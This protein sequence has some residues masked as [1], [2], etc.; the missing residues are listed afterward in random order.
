MAESE[1]AVSRGA[2]RQIAFY[3]LVVMLFYT[4]GTPGSNGLANIPIQYY[5]KDRLHFDAVQTASFNFVAGLPLYFGFLLGYLRDRWRPL[6]RGDLGYIVVAPPLIAAGYLWLAVSPL[7]YPGLVIA[8]LLS[9]TF[10]VLLGASIQGLMTQIAQ[11]HAMAGR[12]SVVVMLTTNVPSI[13]SPWAGGWLTAHRPPQFTFFV[14]ALMALAVSAAA[15]W[16]PRA[17]FANGGVAPT[18]SDLSP[19]GAGLPA[20]GA[21]AQPAYD[22]AVQAPAAGDAGPAQRA[23]SAGA[24]QPASRALPLDGSE[25]ERR[26]AA[27]GHADPVSRAV[28]PDQA[29]PASR[30]LS[31]GALGALLRHPALIFPVAIMFFWNFS[32]GW[33]TPLFYYLTNSVGFSPEQYGSFGSIQN[34][35]MVVFTLVYLLLCRRL[36][37]IRLLWLG[38]VLGVIGA[39][40]LLI[41]HGWPAAVFVAVFTG[42][43][44][45]IAVSAYTDLLM[46]ACPRTLEGTVFMLGS[47]MFALAGACSDV[48]GSWLFK[49]GGFGLA[50]LVTAI[51]TGLILPMLPFLPG[52]L[53]NYRDGEAVASG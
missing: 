1:A 30:T 36:R 41:I 43:A 4:L 51:V 14:A 24:A 16:R 17:V 2:V 3:F 22:A 52:R 40:L 23:A 20:T 19:R 45:S 32:P 35:A 47:G 39:P 53:V 12:L 6:G 34:G 38:T 13:I 37:L 49:Q 25:P 11:R 28:G 42:G 26:S 18:W 50:L 29:E 10:G 33:G 27:L 21:S 7:T 15:F 8:T 44:N 48:F 5:L 46:R 31:L 9:A